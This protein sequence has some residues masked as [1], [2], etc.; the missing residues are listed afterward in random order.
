MKVIL[1][2][3]VP[4]LGQRGELVDVKNGYG[5][6]YLIRQGL[7]NLADPNTTKTIHALKE[8]K[9]QKSQKDKDLVASVQKEL[10]QVTLHFSRKANEK[11]HLFGA[12]SREDIVDS[13]H[14]KGFSLISENS[15]DASPLKTIGEHTILIILGG[16][17]IPIRVIIQEIL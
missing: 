16:Q 5:R 10:V 8:Q 17:K 2:R 13:L 15:I 9:I 14:K 11:G 7:A 4:R 12:V 3:D 1:L 6:N